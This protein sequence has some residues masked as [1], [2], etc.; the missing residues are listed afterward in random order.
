[1]QKIDETKVPQFPA[2]KPYFL[3]TNHQT[4]TIVVKETTPFHGLPMVG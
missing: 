1:M 3:W 4:K 2:T